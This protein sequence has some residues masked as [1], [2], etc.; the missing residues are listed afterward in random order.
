MDFKPSRPANTYWEV[1]V[2]AFRRIFRTERF[3]V[4]SGS[5]GFTDLQTVSFPI[6]ICGILAMDIRNKKEKL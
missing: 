1:E 4:C 5:G 2:S 6:G 3:W